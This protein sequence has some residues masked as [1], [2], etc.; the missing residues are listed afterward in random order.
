M[1]DFEKLEVY[2]KAHSI[3][4]KADSFIKE[5]KLDRT[6]KDQ[7]KRA[8]FSVTLNIAEGTSRFTNPSRRNFMII[9]RGSAFECVAIVNYLKDNKEMTASE[10]DYFYSEFE[11]ISKMLFGLIKKLS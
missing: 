6:T 2:H 3:C 4:L 9:A 5:H 8:A 11:T 1:F 10:H 7:F